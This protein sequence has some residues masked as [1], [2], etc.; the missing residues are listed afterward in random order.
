MAS[1]FSLKILV[2]EDDVPVREIVAE[3]LISGDRP[4]SWLAGGQRGWWDPPAGHVWHREICQHQINRPFRLRGPVAICGSV[5]NAGTPEA[6]LTQ[7]GAP[8]EVRSGGT[9]TGRRPPCVVP[10][11][12][13]AARDGLFAFMTF[14]SLGADHSV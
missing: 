12:H 10:F 4:C 8:V 13:Q 2:I 1:R 3:M 11:A 9:P 7:R 6:L 14:V 5:L